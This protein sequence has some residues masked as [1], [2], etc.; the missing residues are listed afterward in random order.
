MKV[1]VETRSVPAKATPESGFSLL[2]LLV[3]MVI[4]LVVSAAVWGLLRTAQQSRSAV[5]EEVQ[6]A[7]NVRIALSQ[8]SRDAFN[9]GFG[10]PSASTVVLPDNRISTALGVPNDF[11][12]SRDTVPPVIAGNNITLSTFATTANTRTD[13]V[14]FL[15]KD[16][17]F[18]VISGVSQPLNINAATTTTGGIDEIVPI[19][20]SNAAC[21]VNDVYIVIGNTGSTLGLSTALSGTN[22][23]QFSNGDLLGFNQTGTTGPLRA[24]ST[25]ASIQRVRMVTYFVTADGILNRREYANITPAVAFVDEPLVYNVEN[26]QIQYIMDNGSITDNPSAGPDGTAGT[27]DDTQSNLAAVRQIRFTV[28]VRSVEK[29]SNGQPYTESMTTTVSTRNLG[30]DAS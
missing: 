22:K 13:Q 23:I 30:Y 29:N 12:T 14:T 28:N 15:Y 7:K 10:Y 8:I 19:S 9:A 6:L 4:F 21:R 26:F 20:G 11:D 27:A 25:P 17:T 16:N 3:S 1:Q 2:E 18:N 24:I 5:T